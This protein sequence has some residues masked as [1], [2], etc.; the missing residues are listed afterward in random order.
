[1]KLVGAGVKPS[2]TKRSPFSLS[3]FLYIV[4]FWWKG[5]LGE[6]LGEKVGELVSG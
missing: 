6:W 2:G 5:V 3:I 4:H 1:M